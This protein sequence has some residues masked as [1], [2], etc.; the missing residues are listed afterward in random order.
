MDSNRPLITVIT[1]VFND[2][3]SIE[4]TVLSVLNQS[5]QYIEYII[6]DG[7]ST[8]GTYELLTKYNNRIDYLVSEKDNGVYDAMNK[9]VEKSSGEWTIFMNS[10]D[11]F[12][13]NNVIFRI[14]NE[15]IDKGEAIIFGDTY[16]SNRTTGINR[17]IKASYKGK[18]K[19]MPS[20]HQSI[21][22]RTQ[23]LKRHPFDLKYKVISDFAFYYDLYNR[24]NRR[25][26]YNDVV[27][28]YDD[29]GLSSINR[30]L[31]AKEFML[32]FLN[33]FDY[34]FFFY[35]MVF[36]KRKIQIRI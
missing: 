20:A 29:S 7:S 2:V 14:V 8:D 22:T 25:F 19:F 33:R 28:Y 16:Y 5:Y 23:E 3:S 15:Y 27:S 6:I 32:F 26:Y 36:L 31:N 17:Y 12:F 21:L 9:G 34:R 35:L 18:S 4:E 1:V 24:N 10:G 11:K 13:D 30:K